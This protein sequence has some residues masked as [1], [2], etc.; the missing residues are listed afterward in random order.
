[1]KVLVNFFITLLQ[2][3]FSVEEKVVNC[4]PET[5]KLLLKKIE[6]KYCIV[7]S[8]YQGWNQITKFTYNI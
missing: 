7:H 6:K 2:S 5:S 8:K 4:L 3:D 1:M